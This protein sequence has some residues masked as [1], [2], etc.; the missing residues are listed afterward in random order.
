[1]R[2]GGFFQLVYAGL[3]MMGCSRCSK[4]APPASAE[5]TSVSAETAPS[6]A[7]PAFVAPVL[8]RD[9][10]AARA[11]VAE[12]EVG[13]WH[14][15]AIDRIRALMRERSLSEARNVMLLARFD[16][17]SARLLGR[18]FTLPPEIYAYRIGERTLLTLS[19]VRVGAE[20]WELSSESL[21]NLQLRFHPKLPSPLAPPPSLGPA[22]GRYERCEGL[23]RHRFASGTFS[24]ALR[25]TL[26]FRGHQFQI[27]TSTDL[28]RDDWSFADRIDRALS[29]IPQ[30]HLQLVREIVIDP[31]NHPNG[32]VSATTSWDGTRVNMFLAGA[33]RQ[34]KQGDLDATTAHEL[35]HVVSL[36]QGDRLWE[37]WDAAM[38]RDKRGVST[39]GLTNRVEDFAEAYEL[40]LGG[41]RGDSATRARFPSRFAVMDGLFASNR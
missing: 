25:C 15:E 18:L 19:F 4:E 30:E 11:I 10:E 27:T 9:Q 26:G 31:G 33:G 21:E 29:N 38:A 34:V 37:R 28:L 2:G 24:D 3:C 17:R 7:E 35:G 1:M 40:Y 12:T 22:N 39:Y 13:H 8:S 41:G 6:P 20:D 23:G 5:P 16:L 36:Q 32:N 14:R